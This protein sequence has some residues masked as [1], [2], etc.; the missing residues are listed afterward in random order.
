M[1]SSYLAMHIRYKSCSMLFVDARIQLKPWVVPRNQFTCRCFYVVNS[2]QFRLTVLPRRDVSY[3][4]HVL[5]RTAR[6]HQYC[7]SSLLRNIARFDIVW[8]T[9]VI[10]LRRYLLLWSKSGEVVKFECYYWLELPRS[11][12]KW[13]L[14]LFTHSNVLDIR[15]C[16]FKNE[17]AVMS[18]CSDCSDQA[19]R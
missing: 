8:Q 7:K 1:C 3:S 9:K 2:I 17:D 14:I 11:L 10:S 16:H 6:P 18:D 12:T 15:F 5:P 4:L 19:F 13:K